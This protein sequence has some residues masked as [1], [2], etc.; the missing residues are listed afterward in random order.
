MGKQSGSVGG[1]HTGEAPA[2]DAATPASKRNAVFF[3]I[4]CRIVSSVFDHSTQSQTLS[5][6]GSS[7]SK[8]KPCEIELRPIER[9]E[10]RP[11]VAGADT[12][13]WSP[14]ISAACGPLFDMPAPISALDHD[15][16]EIP[17][18]PP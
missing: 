1:L 16:G 3:S 14:S 15:V 11:I 12:G 5:Y 2:S 10:E 18:P 4:R 17:N 8:R 7:L 9:P 6:T 13:R